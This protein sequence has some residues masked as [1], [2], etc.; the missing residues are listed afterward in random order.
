MKIDSVL[1]CGCRSISW[2]D[3]E[4][5]A[6]EFLE[7]M[8]FK[9]I[10]HLSSKDPNFPFDYVAEKQGEKWLIDVTTRTRKPVKKKQIQ[11]WHAL[12]FKTALLIILPQHMM[13]ILV[14]IEPQDTWITLSNTKINQLKT[15]LYTLLTTIIK[16][17]ITPKQ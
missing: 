6:R 7:Y 3:L 11:V 10:Q 1:L 4:R 13:E 14:E 5:E 15:E 17:N 12:G 8:D 9:N 2:Y 16:H